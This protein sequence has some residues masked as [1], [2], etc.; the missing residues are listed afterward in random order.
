[1][2]TNKEALFSIQSDGSE[3]QLNKRRISLRFRTF[4]VGVPLLVVDNFWVFWMEHISHGPYPTFLALFANTVFILAL[5]VLLNSIIKRINRNASLKQAELLAIYLMLNI[6]AAIA[7]YDF[8]PI[9]IQLMTHPFQ[10]AT[11]ENGWIQLFGSH[12]PNWLMMSDPASLKNCYGGNSTI[13]NLANFLPWLK[14]SM[15]WLAFMMVLIYVMMCINVI[16]RKQWMDNERL[17]FPIVQLPLAM[18]EPS[19]IFWR[20]R[21]LWVGFG[22]AAGIGILN[23]LA[24]LFPMLPMVNVRGFDLHEYMMQKPWDAIQRTPITFYPFIIGLGFLLPTDL[25]FSTWFFYL[26]GKFQLILTS[27]WGMDADPQFPYI[28][29]QSVGAFIALFV[30]L[31]WASRGYLKKAWQQGIGSSKN[32]NEDEAMSI[33]S[34]LAGA[35][36]GLLIMSIF[37]SAIGLSPILALLAFVMYFAIAT[38]VTR[39]RAELGPASHDLYLFGPDDLFPQAIGTDRLSPGSLTAFTFLFWFNRS[40]ESQPMAHGLEGLKMARNSGGLQKQFFWVIMIAALVGGIATFWAHLHYSY[41]VGN[42]NFAGGFGFWKGNEAFKRLAGWMNNPSEAN[43]PKNIANAAGF[44]FCMFL[45]ALR[46]KFCDWPFHPIGYAMSGV[47]A[48]QMIWGPCLIAW[49]I[50]STLLRFGG[51]NLYK[52]ALPLFLGII[53][54]DLVVGMIWTLIGMILNITTYSFCV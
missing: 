16:V 54:G 49:I 5:L 19:G 44:G 22:F 12:L 7:C 38:V 11:P 8:L 21:L 28:K 6:G 15:W 42:A 17:T 4:L 34:A 48:T 50:K 2:S 30:S 45:G 36:I 14:P 3:N 29:Q 53:L 24:T 18:T 46:R 52:K 23:G 13:Y 35:V 10:C 39:V 47:W 33:R 32:S 20:N 41:S 40:H 43:F 37:F 31:L 1:M 25:L 9:V 51:N 26:F 27:S